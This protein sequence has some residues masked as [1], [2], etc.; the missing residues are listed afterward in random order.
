MRRIGVLLSLVL[1]ILVT[2]RLVV[3]VYTRPLDVS[4]RWQLPP[5]IEMV[6]GRDEVAYPA[7]V[8]L[9]TVLD[10]TRA[11]PTAVG[12]QWVKA[13][14]HAQ[15]QAQMQRVAIGLAKAQQRATS[16]AE[17]WATLCPYIR[18]S[19]RPS[20]YAAAQQAGLHC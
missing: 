18:P 5:I 6:K 19:G 13:A 17:F 1:V 11:A 20:E 9:A 8:V 15:N 2:G 12:L 3:Q 14:A 10:A 4:G 16:P 7:H